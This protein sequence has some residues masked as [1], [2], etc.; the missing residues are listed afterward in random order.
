MNN[1]IVI[2]E[3]E[4]WNNEISALKG[5]ESVIYEIA[6]FK[7]FVKLEVFLSELFVYYSTG[8]EGNNGYVPMRKLNFEDESHLRG[9]LKSGNSPYIDYLDK[10]INI[11]KHIFQNKKDPFELIFSDAS[12]FVYYN[13]MKT[14]RN[15]IAHESE[16][17][18]R[19]YIKEVLGN[20]DFTEP[21]KYLSKINKKYSKTHYT[22]YTEKIK[23]I[24]EILLEPSDFLCQ[25]NVSSCETI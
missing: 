17:S 10:I 21:Y 14:L 1:S 19:K 25:E 22:I 11:S 20:K 9:V 8:N 23:E 15:Y 4:Y 16:E 2:N 5:K 12:Y 18:K 6:L 13:Q 7:I 3:I 24:T